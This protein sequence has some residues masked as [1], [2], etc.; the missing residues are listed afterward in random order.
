MER[1]TGMT[2]PDDWATT[3]AP[4][5]EPAWVAETGDRTENVETFSQALYAI[6][7][8]LPDLE[9]PG[10][11]AFVNGALES[12]EYSAVADFIVWAQ[13]VRRRLAL[14]ESWAAR[15]LGR[16]VGCPDTID[17]PDGR[18]VEVL[19]G[20]D[21]KAWRHDEW[22][23]DARVAVVGETMFHAYADAETGELVD[24]T[25]VLLDVAARVQAVHGSTAPRAR[26]LKA[27]GLNADDYCETYPG[28]YNL[29]V[30][31]PAPTPTTPTTEV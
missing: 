26:S 8:A 29:K 16:D 14:I 12:L 10:S 7:A 1:V 23:R 19:K 6:T 15:E 30:C 4:E 22:Q 28:P 2:D 3:P 11:A 13:D 18:T 31:A 20:K 9:G 21:R 24:L 25:P 17:L 5:R 27:L